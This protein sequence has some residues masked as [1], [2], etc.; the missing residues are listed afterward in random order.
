LDTELGLKV[1]Q[2][3]ASTSVFGKE[4]PGWE[5]GAMLMFARAQQA[6]GAMVIPVP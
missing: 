4:A 3:S 2:F 5:L 1:A 6:S